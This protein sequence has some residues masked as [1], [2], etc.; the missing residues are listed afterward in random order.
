MAFNASNELTEG[1]G[2]ATHGGLACAVF[3]KHFVWIRLSL[4]NLDA[5]LQA[6]D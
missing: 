2:I 4:L 5:T 1:Q 6:L 3:V